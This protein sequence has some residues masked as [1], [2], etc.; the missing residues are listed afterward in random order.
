MNLLSNLT[1]SDVCSYVSLY[2]GLYKCWLVVYSNTKTEMKFLYIYI[3][4]VFY[5]NSIT[6]Y[7]LI[8]Y[9]IDLDKFVY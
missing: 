7:G 1:L 4:D 8:L 2:V 9:E 5:P 3:S 6:K